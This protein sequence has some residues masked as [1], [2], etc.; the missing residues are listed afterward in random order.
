MKRLTCLLFFCTSIMLVKAQDSTAGLND[1]IRQV[2]QAYNKAAY[3]GFK[4]KYCYANAGKP[5]EYLESIAGEVQMD[6]GRSRLSIDGIETLLTGRYAIQVMPD[7]KVIYVASAGRAAMSNPVSILDTIFGHI[8]GVRSELQHSSQSDI[9]TLTFPPNQPYT[10]LE[11]A[12]DHRTG[13]FERITYN[14]NTAGLVEKDMIDRPGHPAPYQ[15]RGEVTIFFTDYQKGR[16]DDQLFNE[17]NFFTRTGGQFLPVG[18]YR[19]YHIYLASS[20]L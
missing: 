7:E 12:L 19:D 8:H 17:G 20:N 10:R 16:F 5:G 2:Q 11:I 14:L 9:L 6:K 4:V 13:F 15:D 3:L 18:K 1:F